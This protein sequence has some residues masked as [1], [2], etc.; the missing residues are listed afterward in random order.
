MNLKIVALIVLVIA[1][2]GLVYSIEMTSRPPSQRLGAPQVESS[3]E[4]D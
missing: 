1:L 2:F 4:G 3:G